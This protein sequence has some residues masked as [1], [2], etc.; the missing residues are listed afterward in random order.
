MAHL[1]HHLS[2]VQIGQ[3]DQFLLLQTLRGAVD[4]VSGEMARDLCRPGLAGL[5]EAEVETLKRRGYL[6][7]LSP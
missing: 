1:S 5:S 2:H 4:V 3:Q 7:E 6:T